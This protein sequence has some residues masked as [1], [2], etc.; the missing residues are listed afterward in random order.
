L[1]GIF[2]SYRREDSGGW[3]RS[4]HDRLVQA[5][6]PDQVF[7]DV[8][9]IPAAVDFTDFIT[10]RLRDVDAL[11][12]VIGNEWETLASEDGQPRIQD[13]DDLLRREIAIALLIGVKVVPVLVDG[14][15]MP[16]VSELPTD[17]QP[18][19]RLNAVELRPSSFS[20]DTDRLVDALGAV[21]TRGAIESQRIVPRRGRNLAWSAGIGAAIV[22]AGVI[23]TVFL[24]LNDEAPE[25][26]TT[27][28]VVAP[29]ETTTTT[30]APATTQPPPAAVRFEA[31]INV[32]FG[33]S[34]DLE[35]GTFPQACMFREPPFDVELVSSMPTFIRGIGDATLTSMGNQPVG[36]DGCRDA[37]PDKSGIVLTGLPVGNHICA[38]TNEGRVS[39]LVHLG[40]PE[41]VGVQRMSFHITT[42]EEVVP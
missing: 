24:V 17:L 37:P 14:A 12:A 38:R 36:F 9:D 10:Q 42:W 39:E 33:C 27:L 31:D 35:D 2:V 30:T 5:F 26:T 25:T 23:L 28:V 3:A 6:G 16:R 20:T 8:E 29:P 15:S 13:P 18:L 7:M 19:T 21:S 40:A 11:V 41:F 32:P 1:S 22:T 34:F 4:I